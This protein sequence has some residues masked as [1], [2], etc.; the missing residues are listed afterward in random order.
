VFKPLSS[1]F[2]PVTPNKDCECMVCKG[3]DPHFAPLSIPLTGHSG[4]SVNASYT[5]GAQ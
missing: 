4:C 5:V 3:P 1:V 2:D